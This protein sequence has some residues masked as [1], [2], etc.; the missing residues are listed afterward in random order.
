MVGRTSSKTESETFF[1]EGLFGDSHEK[2]TISDGSR[3]VEARGRN[4][5]ES[6]Q[7]ASEKWH[8]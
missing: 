5:E 7:R 3:T 4:A 2:T 6:Q 8:K 1:I